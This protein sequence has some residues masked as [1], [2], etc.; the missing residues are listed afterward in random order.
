[1][2]LLPTCPLP[3]HRRFTDCP[4]GLEELSYSHDRLFSVHPVYQTG[5]RIFA[6]SAP[7]SV[8]VKRALKPESHRGSFTHSVWNI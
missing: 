1:M 4:F 2:A 6:L 7:S 8:S 3:L 5:N